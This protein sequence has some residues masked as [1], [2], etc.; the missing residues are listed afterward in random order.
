MVVPT[1]Y[2]KVNPLLLPLLADLQTCGSQNEE[3]IVPTNSK[4]IDGERMIRTMK[5]KKTNIA[6][7]VE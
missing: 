1:K 2:S 5:V 4:V 3:Y 7:P 6:S